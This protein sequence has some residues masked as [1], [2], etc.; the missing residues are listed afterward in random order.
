MVFTP[1]A[2][3]VTRVLVQTHHERLVQKVHTPTT[4]V[5]SL[6]FLVHRVH[7]LA[8]KAV[9]DAISVHQGIYNLNQNNQNVL[10][11]NLDQS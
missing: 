6:A 11:L 4:R 2:N 8:K 1:F 3:V 7:F 5:P 10:Q 9:L